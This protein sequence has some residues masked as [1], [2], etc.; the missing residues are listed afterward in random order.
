[1]NFLLLGAFENVRILDLIVL[2][3]YL[4][5]MAA[6]GLFMASRNKSTEEYF[7]GGR[8]Y[9]GWIIG[10][11]ML[12]TS[13]SSVSF[14]AFPAD[15]Y[16]G[17]WSNLV[18]NWMLPIATVLAIAVFIP[19]F[20]STRLTSAFEYLG[21]RFGAPLR[22]YGAIGFLLLQVIRIGSILFLV[23]MPVSLLFDVD[24][25]IVII[26]AGIFVGFYTV[27]GGIDAVIWTDVIQSFVLCFGGILCVAYI[28]YQLPGGFGQVLEVGSDIDLNKFSLG[29]FDFDLSRKTFWTVSIL[30]LIHF[31]GQCCSDQTFVQR[32][33]AAKSTREARKAAILYSIFAIPT[34]TFF[35]FLGT[36][37]YVYYLQFPTESLPKDPDAVFP[38][39]ILHQI[40][41][42]IAG[43]VIAGVLAAAMS[44]LDSS[45][46]SI[47]TVF[48]IDFLK[49][50]LAP[51]RED[52][53]YL[54][55][56]KWVA[57][58]FAV[59]MIAGALLFIE[60]TKTYT[61]NQ[62]TWIV[63]SIFGGCLTGLFLVGFFTTRVKGNAAAF[64]VGVSIVAN[65][66]LNLMVFEM[67][68]KQITFPLNELWV[69]A[70][71]NLLFIVV[72]YGASF[73]LP[74]TSEDLSGLTVWTFRKSSDESSN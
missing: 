64:A 23:S 43:L 8:S 48:T 45:L 4:G 71:I 49:P 57:V 3:V 19:L 32:Y 73:L 40:P 44:S 51:N 58:L 61:V 7:V 21:H 12:G 63:A 69:G 9:S 70:I 15:A 62:L 42:G 5:A 59:L 26:C 72:A 54:T 66:Y 55:V 16:K 68:P 33:I 10:I 37:V 28:L 60:L 2:V 41:P 53:Y 20:R 31:I 34:W 13:I 18:S 25:R 24:I 36:C 11:S 30:G 50:Y 74:S 46:N 27:V 1:M 38:Y 35:F 17:N 29:D 65:I 14:L 52:K 6:M 67:L 47:S 56:A 39:F 22:I